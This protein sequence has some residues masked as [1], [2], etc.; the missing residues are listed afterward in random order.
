M[1]LRDATSAD[2]GAIAA[3]WNREIRDGVSTFNTVEK[4][5]GALKAAIA[6]DAVYVVA[7]EGTQVVGF[8]T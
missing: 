8:A 4:D 2:A 3:I 5:Q 7:E 1:I 6:T